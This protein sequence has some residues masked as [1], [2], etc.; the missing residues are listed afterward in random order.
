M[1][2]Y[3]TWNA[4]TKKFQ[5]RKQGNMVPGYPDIRST[6]ALGRIYT[7][8]P[9][10]DEC[11]YLRLL[12]VQWPTPRASACRS[13]S[14]ECARPSRQILSSNLDLAKKSVNISTT[15]YLLADGR[16]EPQKND[17]VGRAS[18]FRHGC[19]TICFVME[20]TPSWCCCSI[21]QRKKFPHVFQCEATVL[22]T[23]FKL[24]ANFY[25][26]LF[27][28]TFLVASEQTNCLPGK[29]SEQLPG[30]FRP[31]LAQNYQSW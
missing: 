8:H 6:D 18:T 27:P 26:E 5:C 31:V 9:K 13:S 2:R 15:D 19:P 10:S 29:A 24:L 12:L 20:N 23:T 1:P 21:Q 3:Y 22:R 4:S 28:V 14:L 16:C 11:F 30:I 17:A 7:V 25:Q